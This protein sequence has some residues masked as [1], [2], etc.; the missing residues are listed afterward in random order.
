MFYG[1]KEDWLHAC[2]GGHDGDVV[3]FK[4]FG[5]I[6]CINASWMAHNQGNLLQKFKI[7]IHI[8]NTSI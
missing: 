3:S 8:Q 4:H 6:V 7:S 1:N 2:M 5:N